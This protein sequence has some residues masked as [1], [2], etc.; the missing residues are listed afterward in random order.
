MAKIKYIASVLL[1]FSAVLLAVMVPGGP[2]G[3]PHFNRI[4]VPLP[5]LQALNKLA[6]PAPW[7]PCFSRVSYFFCSL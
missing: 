3:T 5:Q 7:S 4:T 1:L 2:V 6:S